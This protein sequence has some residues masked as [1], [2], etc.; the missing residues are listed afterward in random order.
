[1]PYPDRNPDL[2]GNVPDS[3]EVALLIVDALNALDFPGSQAFVPKALRAARQIAAL[4]ARAAQSGIPCIYVNDNAGRWRSD[5]GALLT[6]CTRSEAPG[7][8]LGSLLLPRAEDYVVLKPKH[9]GFYSTTLDTVLTYLRSRRLILTGLSLERCLLFTA[10]DAFLRDY[11]LF[12]P[13]DCTAAID[14]GDEAAALRILERVLN[15]N[16]T[17]SVE[18]DLRA[19]RHGK[20]V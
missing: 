12:V 13:R 10:N 19:L 6:S 11:E 17:A 8:E 14:E 1:M 4:K 15:A 2:H 5:L 7:R 3:N 18:L 20:D 9:S 16:T